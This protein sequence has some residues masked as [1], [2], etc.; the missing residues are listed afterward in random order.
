[1]ASVSPVFSAGCAP[2][3]TRCC[4]NKFH[5]S[6][7]SSSLL[8]VRIS[9]WSA[10]FKSRR[11]P[12]TRRQSAVVPCSALAHEAGIWASMQP[13][14]KSY[15]FLLS[16]SILVPLLAFSAEARQRLGMIPDATRSVVSKLTPLLCLHSAQWQGVRR[17]A[18]QI[19]AVLVL[20][21]AFHSDIPPPDPYDTF[22]NVP[23][24]ISGAESFKSL[25]H[26]R[27]INVAG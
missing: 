4:S 24:D 22:E 16:P 13:Q 17:C 6:S 10:E 3:L 9:I 2:P 18:V 19:S 27:G 1:M 11:T 8:S 20:A 12:L 21:N 5:T 26:M 7:P 25:N 23:Q 14:L 15:W